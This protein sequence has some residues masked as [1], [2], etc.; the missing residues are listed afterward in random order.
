MSVDEARPIPAR[1]APIIQA[2][3]LDQPRVV[4]AS[5]LG[6]LAGTNGVTKDGTQLAYDLR[7]LGWLLPLRTRGA[8]EFVPAARAGRLG[9]GDRH[10]E[11]RATLAVDPDFPG[12][13][14]M[15]SAAVAL[16]LAGRV[17]AHEVLSLP[18]GRRRPKA[19]DGWRLV[20]L[21]VGPDAL[22]RIDGLPTWRVETLLAGM[23]CRPDAFE[24]WPNVA[25]WLPRAVATADPDRVDRCLSGAPRAAWLRA[26]YL[27]ATGHNQ[28]A[29][30]KLKAGTPPGHGPVYLGP[31]HLDGRFDKRFEV[32]DSVLAPSFE[33]VQP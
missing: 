13:L 22:T 19:L 30:E 32:I 6:E 31:R 2:L 7:R 27:L 28:N 15:E 3:E 9:A 4:T 1:L 26:G 21:A 24:D 25:E 14:A 29:G 23:A 17:P 12:A 8:W 20:T 5:G 10:I 33:S 11:L 16:G 18:P